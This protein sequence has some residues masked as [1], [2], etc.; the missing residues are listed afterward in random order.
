[1]SPTISSVL[2]QEWE[3]KVNEEELRSVEIW[4]KK[5][6]FLTQTSSTFTPDDSNEWRVVQPRDRRRTRQPIP[7]RPTQHSFSTRYH[8]DFWRD[9]FPAPRFR[10]HQLTPNQQSPRA[11]FFRP[12]QRHRL[13]YNRQGTNFIQRLPKLM[14]LRF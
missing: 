8:Q 11:N 9:R 7:T 14:N 4:S 2:K 12:P 13:H 5:R 3:I 1:M 6:S 10:L